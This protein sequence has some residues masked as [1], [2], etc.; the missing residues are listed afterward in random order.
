MNDATNE[1]RPDIQRAIAHILSVLPDPSL[2]GPDL[3]AAARD[4]LDRY[5]D[6]LPRPRQDDCRRHHVEERNIAGDWIVPPSITGPERIVWLHGG[7]IIGGSIVSHAPMA[8]VLASLTGRPVFL[9]DYRLAPEHTMPAAHDDCFAAFLWAQRNAPD[10]TTTGPVWLMGD[11]I[12]AGLA[13]STCSRALEEGHALPSRLALISATLNLI[14]DGRPALITDPLIS[15]PTLGGLA[16][17]ARDVPLSDPR[18]STLNLP[19]STL[20]RFPPTLLQV[21]GGEYLLPDSL[22]LT[23]RLARLARPVRLSIWPDMPHVWH[24]F[25]TSLPEANAALREI[26]SFLTA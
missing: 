4:A 20:S 22:A 21:S 15:G 3:I 17:Y 24:S 7:G 9:A 5:G 6:A 14:P 11:S 18:L 13:M 1:L 12:G 26:A 8:E 23:D 19:D 16:L 2:T 10:G 25:V